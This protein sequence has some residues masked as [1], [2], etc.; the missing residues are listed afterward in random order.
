M[1]NKQIEDNNN[2]AQQ[3][4]E[5]NIDDKKNIKL[6]M[7]TYDLDE[8]STKKIYLTLNKNVFSVLRYISNEIN[9]L[10][11]ITS[12]TNV[13][14]EKARDIYYKCNKDVVESITYILNDETDTKQI[15]NN[16]Q[17][18]APTPIFDNQRKYKHVIEYG[19]DL[20]F[21]EENNFLFDAETKEFFCHMNNATQKI[22]EL[23]C[24]VD[25]KDTIIQS[26]KKNIKLEKLEYFLEDYQKELLDWAKSKL[27]KWE[28]DEEL[29][30]KYKTKNDYEIKLE[31][32]IKLKYADEMSIYK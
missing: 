11:I 17:N 7:E 26:Q 21:D 5:F 2:S 31:N 16:Q 22:S 20:F 10:T 25:A 1:E 4:M 32:E 24:M 9:N 15:I 3:E 8:I 28:H 14:R 29:Q 23:R 27:E 18:E 13:D 12:Q 6:I 19:K 30:T